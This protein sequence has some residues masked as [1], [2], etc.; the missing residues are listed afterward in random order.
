[1][2]L[3]ANL[4]GTDF[5]KE[6]KGVNTGLMGVAP[7]EAKGVTAHWLH[8]DGVDIFRNF[9]ERNQALSAPLVNAAGTRT[10]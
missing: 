3:F 9:V 8:F 2:L 1:M 5:T 10:V 7:I 4:A 6:I